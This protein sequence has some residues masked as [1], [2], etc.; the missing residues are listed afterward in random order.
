MGQL[1]YLPRRVGPAFRSVAFWAI[2]PRGDLIVFV[3]GFNGN[4][5]S[6]WTEFHT[7]LP[8]EARC[9]SS[10]IVFYGYDGL[11]AYA[12]VSAALFADFLDALASNPARVINEHLDR[13]AHRP[14][15]FS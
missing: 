7:L 14:D 3:H 1:H 11:R 15:S 12:R 10:D 6:T 2:E 13:E 8:H 4:A 5:V 9:S